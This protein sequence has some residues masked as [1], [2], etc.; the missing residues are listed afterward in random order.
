PRTRNPT[1]AQLNANCHDL[2]EQP[3][4]SQSKIIQ[5]AVKNGGV[6]PGT[7]LAGFKG[8]LKR[9]LIPG[10]RL[11]TEMAKRAAFWGRVGGI[12]HS[13]ELPGYGITEND[14]GIISKKLGCRP[15]DAFVLVAHAR[16]KALDGLKAA[17]ERAKEALV[18]VPEETRTAN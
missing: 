6:V 5:S 17:V 8:L 16:E 13:D 1:P 3:S 10:I 14:V 4:P 11:G 2:T 18:G 12:F 15:S 9:E 7:R